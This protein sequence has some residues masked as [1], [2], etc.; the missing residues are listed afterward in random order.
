[1]NVPTYNAV[2]GAIVC[3]SGG[4]YVETSAYL[5]EKARADALQSEVVRLCDALSIIAHSH[6]H[7]AEPD[8]WRTECG[9]IQQIAKDALAQS[10]TAPSTPFANNIP[11]ASKFANYGG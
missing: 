7:I 11:P 9:M 4:Q 6:A 8:D 1:M 3:V 10:D 5:A 2:C